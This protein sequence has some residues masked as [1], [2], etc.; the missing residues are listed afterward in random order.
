[1]KTMF[2][3]LVAGTLTACQSWQTR[4]PEQ[5]PPQRGA[6]AGTGAGVGASGSAGSGTAAGG[7]HM[8]M[9]GHQ[10]MCSMHQQMMSARTPEERQAMMEQAMPGMPR[11]ERE[12]HLQM[13]QQ[14]CQ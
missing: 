1:M 2:V 13:M 5:P 4:A 9:Q 7:E 8:G 11:E 12:R 3:V 14:M 10:D 6:S